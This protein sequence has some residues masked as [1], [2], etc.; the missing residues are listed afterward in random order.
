LSLSFFYRGLIARFKSKYLFFSLF[1]KIIGLFVGLTNVI[2]DIIVV[3]GIICYSFYIKVIPFSKIGFYLSIIILSFFYL[4]SGNLLDYYYWIVETNKGFLWSTVP[5]NVMTLP[6]SL[7][8]FHSFGMF[9]DN[10]FFLFLFIF[11]LI[12]YSRQK[13]IKFIIFLSTLLILFQLDSWRIPEIGYT[14]ASQTYKNDSNMGIGIIIVLYMIAKTNYRINLTE[15]YYSLAIIFLVILIFFYFK[16]IQLSTEFNNRKFS[17]IRYEVLIKEN[18]LCKQN[19]T[20][21]NNNCRCLITM[22]WIQDFYLINDVKPCKYFFSSHSPH[23]NEDNNYTNR[24]LMLTKSK[25]AAFLIWDYDLLN[26]N[27]FWLHK[28]I[29]SE[30]KSMNCQVVDIFYLCFGGS[31]IE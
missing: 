3:F 24:L 15:R 5:S 31:K 10:P 13:N 11:Y 17:V 19:F 9:T 23:L 7:F 27:S 12:F 30:F 2:F 14:I 8:S 25:Q 4:L 28:E 29:T 18:N 20:E 1:F 6:S 26:R 22:T 16:N 21:I